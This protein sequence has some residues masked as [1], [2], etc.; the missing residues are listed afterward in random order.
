[1]EAN[2]FRYI[3]QHS[4][5]EQLVIFAV[6]IGSLP[7]YFMSLDLPK[8]IVNEAIQGTAFRDGAKE[9]LSFRF[10]L[11]LPSFLGGG[12]WRVFDGITLDQMGLLFALS[13]IFLLLVLINGAFKYWINVAKGALGE[14]MLRRL[15]FDLVTQLF[16]FTPRTLRGVK[17]SEV[18]TMV[19]DE[20]E[21]VGGF[22]GDAFVLPLFVGTQAAT[23]MTFILIQNVWLGILAGGVVAIQLIVIPRL[24]REQ[25][26]LGKERQL[27]SRK[28]A[29]RV[30]EIV[31]GMQ[32]IR[33][34]GAERWEHADIGYRLHTLFDIRFRL[35][36]RKFMVKYLNNLLAQITP[37]F[38]YSIGGYFALTGRLDIGQ[39]VAVI[40]AYRELPPPL[41]ELIDW[42]QQRL[43]VQIKYDQVVQ[44]FS[45]EEL[46]PVAGAAAAAAA[47]AREQASFSEGTL[48]IDNLSLADPD[49]GH[50]LSAV[51]LDVALPAHVGLVGEGEGPGA[52]A[53]ILA[54]LVRPTDGE[55]RLGTIDFTQ[56]PPAILR[57]EIA[58]AGPDA[59]LF[60]GSLRESLLYG[61][62]KPPELGHAETPEETRRRLEAQ[63]TGNPVDDPRLDWI[64]YGKLGTQG[65]LEL[66]RSLLAAIEIVG[67]RVDVYRLGLSGRMPDDLD[68]AVQGRIV[69]ARHALRSALAETAGRQLVEPFD[70]QAYNAQATLIENVLFGVA[71]E[72]GAPERFL[73]DPVFRRALEE[74]KLEGELQRLGERIAETMTEI[75]RDLPPGHPLFSQFSFIDADDLDEYAD[76]LRRRGMKGRNALTAADRRMLMLL[77]LEYIEPRHRL[78]LVDDALSTKVIET[79]KRFRALSGTNGMVEF[80][81]PDRVCT[82]APMRDNLL[83]GRIA[84]G[85]SNAEAT[86]VEALTGV[87]DKLGLREIVE[88]VGLASE[89]GPGGRLLTAQQRARISLARCIVKRPSWLVLDHGLSVLGDV[90]QAK[91]LASLARAM[92]GRTMI[93]ASRVVP[94]AVAFDTLLRFEGARAVQDAGNAPMPT[95]TPAKAERPAQEE[96]AS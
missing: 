91:V 8:R 40:G 87:V 50:V 59:I 13:G 3:W 16:R 80:Y 21:P 74:T 46:L 41:K 66:D 33:V 92:A 29:G 4:W 47:A 61:L 18:A 31:D 42:D 23:A 7:F 17:S 28:F 68:E 49:G 32:A 90:E 54:G 56:L 48:R 79:R 65:A 51:G 24:R 27:A 35:Y 76:I 19:K 57:Q 39:L 73:D 95:P 2:L 34:H 62:R 43:D 6:V 5:R 77:P 12:S 71:R 20:V 81:D 22:I 67:M 96:A 78:G 53:Q 11:A 70:P 14:R 94:D 72:G 52:L 93:S 1:M 84:Y 25:L 38:F 75:F 89:V 37:F 55:I 9:V 60:P 85:A 36:K 58:Y 26:R 88:R 86:V 82:A 64:D 45:P 30:G 69:E 83:F 63:R 15:R 44:Q 10:D